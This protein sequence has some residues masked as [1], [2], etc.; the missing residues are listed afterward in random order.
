MEQLDFE[1]QLFLVLQLP[2]LSLQFSLSFMSHF[3]ASFPSQED[4]LRGQDFVAVAAAFFWSPL[5]HPAW[6]A[7]LANKTIEMPASTLVNLLMDILQ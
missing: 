7:T 3:A 6:R 1:E 5:Q 2:S 4:L